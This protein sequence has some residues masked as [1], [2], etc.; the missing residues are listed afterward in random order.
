MALF[1]LHLGCVGYI[2]QCR[3]NSC[4]VFL[5]MKIELFLSLCHYFTQ[6]CVVLLCSVGLISP[7]AKKNFIVV[8]CLKTS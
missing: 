3:P 5:E 7:G 1:H 8:K 4:L 6:N 2:V